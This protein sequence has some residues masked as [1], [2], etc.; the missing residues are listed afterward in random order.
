[1]AKIEPLP[2][3]GQSFGAGAPDQLFEIGARLSRR[4]WS[5]RAS[6]EKDEEGEAGQAPRPDDLPQQE[7]GDDVATEDCV[8]GQHGVHRNQY[9]LGRDVLVRENA[10]EVVLQGD[11]EA[12]FVPLLDRQRAGQGF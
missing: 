9:L 1:V 4:C 2:P 7:S 3:L 5:G 6:D 11:E 12:V 8:L 10:Q